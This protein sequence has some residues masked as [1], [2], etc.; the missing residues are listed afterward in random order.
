MR[1]GEEGG[2][3]S[4]STAGDVISSRPRSQSRAGAEPGCPAVEPGA[5]LSH[6]AP[7]HCGPQLCRAARP[8]AWG[9]F[10]GT[11]RALVTPV[12]HPAFLHRSSG[13]PCPPVPTERP[14]SEGGPWPAIAPRAAQPSVCTW[15]GGGQ[16]CLLLGGAA[17]PGAL[18]CDSVA[19]QSTC[20]LSGPLL[21]CRRASEPHGQHVD[22]VLGGSGSGRQE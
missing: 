14:V 11:G 21:T 20:H 13:L 16:G 12:L 22:S 6:A 9:W 5:W 19:G 1:A 2:I 8:V 18:R 10:L 17:V 7:Q 15:G 4:W 3:F